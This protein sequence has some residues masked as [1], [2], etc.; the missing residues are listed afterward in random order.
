MQ[1][2]KN[3]LATGFLQALENAFETK[4]DVRISVLKAAGHNHENVK[5]IAEKIISH[6]G[7]KYTYRVVGFTIFLKK[8]KKTKLK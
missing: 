5:E 3:G 4:Q 2:G 6:L 7:R 8:W 1:I